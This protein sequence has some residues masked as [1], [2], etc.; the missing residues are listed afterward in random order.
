MAVAVAVAVAQEKDSSDC[1][2]F[3]IFICASPFSAPR[4]LLLLSSKSL[5]KSI[6]L[7]SLSAP[8]G[9][10]RKY[11]KSGVLLGQ[12][13]HSLTHCGM[14]GRKSLY[15]AKVGRNRSVGNG[16]WQL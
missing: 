8:L 2:H 6:I 7:F 10:F 4:L 13:Y 9:A 16:C 11:R 5:H 1:N 12:D 15:G 3:S 14:T